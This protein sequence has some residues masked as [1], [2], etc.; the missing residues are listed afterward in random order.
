MDA[1]VGEVLVNR[2]LTKEGAPEK[3]HIGKPSLKVRVY[4]RSITLP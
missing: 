2:V 4:S 1:A 3:R